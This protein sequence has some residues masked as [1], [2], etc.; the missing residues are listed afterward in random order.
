MTKQKTLHEKWK[1]DNGITIIKKSEK[2]QKKK[3]KTK[4]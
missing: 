4:R 2:E 3:R 1:S